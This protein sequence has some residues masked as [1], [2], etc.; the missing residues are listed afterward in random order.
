MDGKHMCGAKTRQDGGRPCRNT[1]LFPNG[2]CK[3]HG[4]LST[5]PKTAEGK[6]RALAN[7]KWQ[8]KKSFPTP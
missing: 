1:R 2:R 4:G 7:L 6:A 3:S 8:A 5:G